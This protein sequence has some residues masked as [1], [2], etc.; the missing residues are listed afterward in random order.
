M[1]PSVV[2]AVVIIALIG[3]VVLVQFQIRKQYEVQTDLG[4]DDAFSAIAR[5]LGGGL[6][7]TD[8]AGD[9]VIPFRGG[10]IS[11]AQVLS[12][13]VV[14]LRVWISRFGFFG[15]DGRDVLAYKRTVRR[16]RRAV[17]VG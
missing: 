6:A 3:I 14:V 10:L 9:L 7:Q 8:A 15:A 1:E 12:G 4:A 5:S 11:V 17:A 2:I 13:E 16:I